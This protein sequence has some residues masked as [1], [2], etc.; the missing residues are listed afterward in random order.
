M[1]WKVSAVYTVETATL[2]EA[3]FATYSLSLSLTPLILLSVS[4]RTSTTS[5]GMDSYYI[6]SEIVVIRYSYS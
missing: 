4:N 1:L 6:K 5:L 2:T 3:E